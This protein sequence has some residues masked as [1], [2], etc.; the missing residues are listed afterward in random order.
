MIARNAK[1]SQFG[2]ELFV[3]GRKN[4]SN[5]WFWSVEWKSERIMDDDGGSNGKNVVVVVSSS[6]STS[7]Y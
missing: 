3:Y 7:V 4:F 5:G 2:G 1:S 6:S